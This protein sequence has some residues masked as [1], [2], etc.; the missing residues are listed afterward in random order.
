MCF[1]RL[2]CP[3]FVSWNQKQKN[4]V[5]FG[6]LVFFGVSNLYRNN[7][8]KQNCFETNRNNHKFSE[9]Y[10]NLLSIKLFR[11]VFCL[12]GFHRK[13]ETLCFGIEAKQTVKKQIKTTLNF[14]KNIPRYALYQT[15]SVALL[16]VTV[17]LKQRNSLLKY[18][19]LRI[20]LTP[21][22]EFALFLC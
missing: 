16:F 3:R 7:R 8:N 11:L 10:Q 6:F 21:I 18:T 4:S 22:L 1:F 14:L 19:R 5:C 12:F 9:K 13:I 2:G 20:F 15:V 17:Q